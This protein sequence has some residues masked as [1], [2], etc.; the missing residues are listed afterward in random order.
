MKADDGKGGVGQKFVRPIRAYGG[1]NLPGQRR[2]IGPNPRTAALPFR[3]GVPDESIGALPKDIIGNGNLAL[4]VLAVGTVV[5][6][7]QDAVGMADVD[8]V[9]GELWAAVAPADK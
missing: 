6:H 7:Y 1:A 5:S 3:F 4:D 8:Q 2:S 9:A